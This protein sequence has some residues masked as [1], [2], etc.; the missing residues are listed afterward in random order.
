MENKKNIKSIKQL[1]VI[2]RKLTM[3][4]YIKIYNLN[5]HRIIVVE[6]GIHIHHFHC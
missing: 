6:S 4:F 3:T 5:Q 2:V 1:K